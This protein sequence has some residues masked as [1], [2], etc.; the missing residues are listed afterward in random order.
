[1]FL[2]LE[3]VEQSQYERKVEAILNELGIK[4][5]TTG[6]KEGTEQISV[7]RV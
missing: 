4:L 3:R 7:A 6:R 2:K 5:E 1:M